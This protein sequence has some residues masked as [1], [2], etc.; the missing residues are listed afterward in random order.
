MSIQN[1]E[2]N[3]QCDHA[4]SDRSKSRASANRYRWVFIAIGMVCCLTS[5]Q[6]QANP[7]S[8]NPNVPL[9]V[10]GT[11]AEAKQIHS[12][13]AGLIVEMEKFVI[14]TIE[15]VN[16]RGPEAA[17][18]KK[19]SLYR[20]SAAQGIFKAQRLAVL[21]EPAAIDFQLRFSRAEV[22][23]QDMVKNYMMSPAGQKLRANLIAQ[24]KK[25]QPAREK[26][27]A[28]A[29]ENLEKDNVSG[30]ESIMDPLSIEVEGLIHFLFPE[31][32]KPYIGTYDP[33]RAAVQAAALAKRNAQAKEAFTAAITNNAVDLQA[34][35]EW[36]NQ[37]V[38]Q[39]G[40]AGQATVAGAAAMDGP[41]AVEMVKT[42]WLAT[43]A[44]LQ[45]LAGL[46]WGLYPSDSSKQDP[47]AGLATECQAIALDS[48]KR[49]IEADATS[50]S[51]GNVQGHYQRYL[52]TLA[53]LGS[54]SDASL[55]ESQCDAALQK[56]LAKNSLYQQQVEQYRRA[57]R[58]LF[59]FD[60]RQRTQSMAAMQ[61]KYPAADATV[62]KQV[63]IVNQQPGLLPAQSTVPVLATLMYPAHLTMA[64]VG[65]RVVNQTVSMQRIRALS[66]DAKVE[67]AGLDSRTYGSM[68][69]VALPAAEQARVASLLLVDATHAPLSV[70]ANVAWQCVQRGNYDVGGGQIVSCQL[71]PVV[72]RFASMPDAASAIVPLGTAGAA[73][74]G[75]MQL[76]QMMMRVD[77]VPQWV[78]YPLGFYTLTS[79]PTAA[80]A[81]SPTTPTA[82]PPSAGTSPV[83]A[84]ASQSAVA[85][86]AVAGPPPVAAPAA[87]DT[88]PT[89]PSLGAE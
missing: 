18:P 12:E 87:A 17:P 79:G 11:L 80:P 5:N 24:V 64:T 38:T 62:R 3:C 86:P 68:L 9:S 61:S 66:P 46:H 57:T 77:I 31:E 39:I 22:A 69:K 59:E 25:T 42:Q 89:L 44:R 6:V 52:T 55:I 48:V 74:V 19:L 43:H 14:E 37:T 15:Q 63:E 13:L 60:K 2:L 53:D 81:S 4:T 82:A 40:T 20:G 75:P 41:A 51:P 28:Q 30:A 29:R 88:V 73:S 70:A 85:P 35:K 45:R 56:L 47:T 49:I 7:T 67:V 34:W 27:L 50:V 8:K 33:T 23:I 71:E 26:K 21:G 65:P 10:H 32:Y 78:M 1:T 72:A 58:D 16:K 76:N 36:A 84:A 83:P 54:L